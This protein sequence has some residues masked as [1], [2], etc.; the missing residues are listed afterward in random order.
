MPAPK[1]RAIASR[2]TMAPRSAALTSFNAPPN[3]PIGVRHALRITA[4]KS[5]SI[6]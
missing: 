5:L 2:T 6:Q 1:A 3:A 4:S